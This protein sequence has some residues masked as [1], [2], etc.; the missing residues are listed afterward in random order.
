[1]PRLP[2]VP[3]ETPDPVVQ[4]VFERSHAEGREPIALYRALANHPGMLRA[5]AALARELRYEARTPRALREL[6]ILRIGQL[7]GSEYEWAHHRAMAA[8]AGVP[9]EQVREL[10][11]W[12]TSERF[13]AAERA[14]L[15][16]A[17]E[18]HDI[19][20]SDAGWAELE[21]ALGRPEAVEIV[22]TGAFYELVARLIQGFGLEV[23]PAYRRW[24][25]P[26]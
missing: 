24:L 16:C 6:M 22:L 12:R 4:E 13:G 19:A 11:E 23:E 26:A 8:A 1:M 14:V 10:A 3:D 7:A 21:G 5:Y 18:L 9:G 2:L 17:D 20:V 15:R 25:G